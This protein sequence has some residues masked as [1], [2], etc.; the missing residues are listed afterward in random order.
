MSR[1]SR[2]GKKRLEQM[3]RI[4]HAGEYAA[5][6]IYEGQVKFTRDPVEKRKIQKMAENEE[7][8]LEYFEKQIIDN[9]YRPTALQPLVK[10][11]AYGVGA[12]SAFFG[13]NAAML[14]THAVED[15]ISQHYKEQEEILDDKDQDLKEH[16][17]RFRKEEEEHHD[18]AENYDLASV[19]GGK[20]FTKLIKLGCH[21]GIKLTKHL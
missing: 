2:N 21:F 5:K 20:F 18:I 17:S 13:K 12:L 11:I 16:I 10:G 7:E 14:C 19:S 4:N 1:Y 9:Q 6:Y 15:V 3:V 8:H